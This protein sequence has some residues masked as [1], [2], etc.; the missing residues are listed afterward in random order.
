MKPFLCAGLFFLF[1]G[2]FLLLPSPVNA[3]SGLSLNLQSVNGSTVVVNGYV[4]GAQ[5]L[6]WNWGDGNISSGF[7]PTTHIYT[8]TGTYN[9]TVDAYNGSCVPYASAYLIVHITSLTK[10]L[11]KNS[12][13]SAYP[14]STHYNAFSSI[15]SGR[16][17]NYSVMAL[18]AVNGLSFGVYNGTASVIVS[19]G[20]NYIYNSTL[21]GNNFNYVIIKGGNSFGYVNAPKGCINIEVKNVGK[22]KALF[23]YNLYNAGID[24]STA[25]LI[26][27]PPQFAINL[28]PSQT[29][30]NTG[31]YF[32]L[33][34]P[35]YSKPTPLAIWIGEGFSGT[36]GKYW[37][38]QIGFNNWRGDYNI[39]YA[40]WGIFSN[41]FGNVGGADYNYPLTP[42]DVYNFSMIRISNTN[43]GFLVNGTP[44]VE[45]NL[46]GYFN[47]TS[48][49][50]NDGATL[51]LETLTAAAESINITNFIRIPLM[52]GF[53]VNGQKVYPNS[54]YLGENGIGENWWN[55]N[56]T[57]SNGISMWGIEG[58]LQNPSIGPDEL[59]FND[60]FSPILTVPMQSGLDYPIYGHFVY[61]A[62][63]SG[64]ASGIFNVSL[65]KGVAEI[66][67]LNGTFYASVNF[68]NQNG[69]TY[70]IKTMVISK[71]TNISTNSSLLRIYGTK[72]YISFQS[73][74]LHTSANILNSTTNS[75]QREN[76]SLV[77]PN[78]SNNGAPDI[79]LLLGVAGA[80]ILLIIIVYILRRR[81]NL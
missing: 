76:S 54:I 60:S 49:V 48:N 39:S 78:S 45:G 29:P 79:Y 31:M 6:V 37:W 50:S 72:N 63:N 10:F 1:A 18:S 4:T 58:N 19:D 15:I 27:Y 17:T 61:A 75:T 74:E 20:G 44:I 57:G 9:I 26:M 66:Y 70:R 51:G 24:N 40:G 68:L 33:R 69:S 73:L 53:L 65:E 22:S 30:T 16:S 62:G 80:I 32:L 36:N 13:M 67:P 3:S 23:A 21:D 42:G 56:A 47:V 64:S 81:A 8:K 35:I 5:Y 7:F 14:L 52:M 43:W 11:A 46:D 25:S 71:P 41:I 12:T 55:G 34:A 28:V 77:G 38:A 2:L 59:L